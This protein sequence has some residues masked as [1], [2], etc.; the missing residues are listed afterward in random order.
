MYQKPE[1]T[2]LGTFREVTQAGITGPLDGF[3]IRNDG[4]GALNTRCS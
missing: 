4:C 3:A 2:K 1:L